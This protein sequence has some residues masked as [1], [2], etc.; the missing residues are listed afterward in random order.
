MGYMQNRSRKF[1]LLYALLV[2]SACALSAFAQDAKKDKKPKK[3]SGPDFSGTYVLDESRSHDIEVNVYKL[4]LPQAGPDQK[5]TN[6]LV[7]EQKEFEFKVST[8]RRIESFDDAGKLIKTEE[9]VQSESTFYGDKRGEKNKFNT[10][11]LYGSKTEQNGRE[12]VVSIA[13]DE[14][15]RLY[16]LLTFSLS[17]DG[18][19]LSFDSSGYKLEPDY[20]IG[21]KY[22]S[23]TA[24]R[25]KKFYIKAG[26]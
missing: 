8:K 22:V 7:I 2:I 24:L 10:D 20:T 14:K 9:M 4:K 17:K 15:R 16:N 12:I 19:E 13:V 21:Q 3:F 1:Y 25:S 11:T 6:L 18:K 23:P 5:I 26:S